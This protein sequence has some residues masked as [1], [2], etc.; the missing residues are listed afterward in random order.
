MAEKAPEGWNYNVLLLQGVFVDLGRIFAS[1]QLVLPFLYISL[2][3]PTL[4]AGMIVPLTQLARMV[5]QIV[6]APLLT[7]HRVL[8]WYMALG[9]TIVAGSLTII[10]MTAHGASAVAIALLFLAVATAVGVGEGLG[11]LAFQ[12]LIHRIMTR[13]RQ[14]SL[15][16]TQRIIGGVLGVMVAV[17][18]HFALRNIDPLTSHITLLWIGIA[19]IVASVLTCMA[20]RH[21]PEPRDTRRTAVPHDQSK[22]RL[23]QLRDGMALVGAAPAFRRFS[24]AQGL[25]LS[26]SLAMPFYAIHATLLHGG[27]AGA[28][29]I[30]VIGNSLGMAAGGMVWRR[31]ANH[32]LRQTMA[33]ATGVAALGGVCALAIDHWPEIRHPASYG[34]VFF[35][36]ALASQ[37][38]AVPRKVYL[39]AI[40][41]KADSAY[42]VAVSNAINGALGMVFAFLMGALAH[43]QHVIWPI[44]LLVGMSIVAGIYVMTLPGTRRSTAASIAGVESN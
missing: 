24:I 28:L 27:T 2:G 38:V 25:M 15:Q 39:L 19:V 41:P 43:I 6:A 35:L 3:A 1:P 26:V 20:I 23:A 29:S 21:T 40:A 4:F 18:S 32:S 16:F 12:S 34:I 5:S 13:D 37:G 9:L 44:A 8:K 17:A 42:Y 10:G 33:A 22:G 36:V 31:Q 14:S 11:I 30:F 7:S